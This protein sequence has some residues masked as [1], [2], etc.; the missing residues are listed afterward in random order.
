[1]KEILSGEFQ[2]RECV[3]LNQSLVSVDDPR[4]FIRDQNEYRAK[5]Y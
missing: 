3:P 2:I 1:M 4:S 5:E